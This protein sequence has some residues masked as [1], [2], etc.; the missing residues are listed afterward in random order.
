MDEPA[1][2]ERLVVMDAI[3]IVEALERCDA[4]SL[5][6][7]GSGHHIGEDAPDELA[8]ALVEFACRGAA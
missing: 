3:P 6:P 5:S 7:G 8:A 4:A 2:V 1:A